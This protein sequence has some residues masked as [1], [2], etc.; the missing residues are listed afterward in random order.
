MKET[1]ILWRSATPRQIKLPKGETFVARYERSSRQNLLRNAT[2]RQTR[3]IGPRIYEQL[4]RNVTVRRKRHAQKGGSGLRELADLG[5]KFG[6]KELFKKGLY[7]GWRVLTSEIGQKLINE[8]I[9]HTPELYK[10]GTF[11]VENN[12]LKKGLECDVANY[13]VEETRKKTKK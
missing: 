12:N 8:G 2:V 3:W 4:H 6:V 13:I 9:K 1:I 10:I 5:M 7:V 11:K